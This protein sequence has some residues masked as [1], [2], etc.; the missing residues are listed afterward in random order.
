ME[1]RRRAWK[2]KATAALHAGPV[3]RETRG[4]LAGSH[5]SAA[6]KS[7]RAGS[8]PCIGLCA[9]S[10]CAM[11]I[12][13]LYSTCAACMRWTDLAADAIRKA[14]EAIEFQTGIPDIAH[15]TPAAQLP[16]AELF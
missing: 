13:W 12:A 1:A 14:R 16:S 11:A 5:G 15:S 8:Q 6:T 3:D 7:N 9:R 2:E 10:T 4:A